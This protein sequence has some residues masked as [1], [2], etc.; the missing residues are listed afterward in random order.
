MSTV[1]QFVSQNGGV[2]VHLLE[3]QHL[4]GFLFLVQDVLG[5]LLQFLL[6]RLYLHLVFCDFSLALIVIEQLIVDVSDLSCLISDLP[7]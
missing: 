4:A 1:L 2:L 6:R 3:L 5:S 7:L